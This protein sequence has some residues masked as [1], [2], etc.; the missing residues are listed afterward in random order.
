MSVVRD[1]AHGEKAF[2]PVSYDADV[3][4]A[5]RAIHNGT[6]LGHQQTLLWEWLMYVTAAGDGW[7]DLSFRPGADGQRE[8]DFM[9]GRRFVGLQFKKM[10]HPRVTPKVV[11]R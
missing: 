11:K 1:W 5:V 8:T 6:A 7:D 4:A 2:A 9:E 10:L 3:V